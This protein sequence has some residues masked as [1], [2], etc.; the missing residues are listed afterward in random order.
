[1]A[2]AAAL[3]TAIGLTLAFPPADQGWLAWL[4]LVPLVLVC[5]RLT[6]AR[7]FVLGGLAGAVAF[8]AI[9]AWVLEAPGFRWYHAAIL[10]VYLALYPAAWCAALPRL[11]R[12]P[13]PLVVTAPALWAGL[14]WVRGNAAFLAFPWAT[15]AH[16]QHANLPLLQTAAVGG[17]AAVTSIVVLANVALAGLLAGKPLRQ[18]VAAAG[19]LVAVYTAGALLLAGAP[20]APAL[21]VAAVQPSIT[22]RERRAPGGRAVMLERLEALTLTAAASR[23]AVIVWPATSVGEL[24]NAPVLAARLDALA[25]RAATPLLVGAAETLKFPVE[26]EG[27]VVMRAGALYNSAHLVAP[28]APRAPA[29]RKRRLLPFAEYVPVEHLVRW[30]AWLVPPLTALTPGDGPRVFSLPGGPRVGALIC[31]ES[32]FAGLARDAV[33]DGAAVLAV[34]TNDEWF[35]RSAAAV[36]HNLAAVLR[37]VEARVPVVVA[38][39][40]GPSQIVDPYGRVIASRPGLFEP[41]VVMA[42]VSTT[43]SPSVYTRTGDVVAMTALGIAAFGLLGVRPWRTS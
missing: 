30:P 27:G 21:G 16:S 43:R 7:A 25:R 24:T 42:R 26:S 39:N 1:M 19:V 11:A 34:L 35:G 10:A 36:Q 28:G 33:R 32:M 8:V 23:P 17:E 5:P 12:A 37:A 2:V 14:E 20:A 3:A 22:A 40:T 38:S 18:A 41:A 9:H 15:L 6:A 4:A 31:W 29:Y 13:L